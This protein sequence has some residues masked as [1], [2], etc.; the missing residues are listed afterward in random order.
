M[1][2]QRWIIRHQQ[3]LSMNQRGVGTCGR[4]GVLKP[5]EGFFFVLLRFWFIFEKGASFT[6]QNF[7]SMII[8]PTNHVICTIFSRVDI[9]FQGISSATFDWT[10][11]MKFMSDVLISADNADF[12]ENRWKRT[13][14]CC[15]KWYI[16]Y[17]NLHHINTLTKINVKI[18]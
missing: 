16:R 1:D 12:M 18:D 7:V 2:S 3:V 13:R 14:K 6:I 17:W 9:F 8:R 5:S 11:W 15:N 4:S 10:V